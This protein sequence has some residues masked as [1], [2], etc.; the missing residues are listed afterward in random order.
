MTCFAGSLR[1]QPPLI[2]PGP[3]G[4]FRERD[5]CDIQP[6][7]GSDERRLYSQA[8]SPDES[9]EA[10][11]SVGLRIHPFHPADN[12]FFPNVRELLKILAV[13]SMGSTKAERSFS[14][15]WR[16]QHN[17]HRTTLILG[18][19]RHACKYSYRKA[20]W[21]KIWRYTIGG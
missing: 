18:R 9:L 15:V 2:A 10:P 8:I 7:S 17:D 12:I 21:R 6:E 4:A 3:R 13:L 1:I 19:H 20:G 14:S 16:T 5:V 11:G